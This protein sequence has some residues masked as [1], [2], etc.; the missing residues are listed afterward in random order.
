[1]IL[2]LVLILCTYCNQCRMYSSCL[3]PTCRYYPAVLEGLVQSVDYLLSM[4]SDA[5]FV[6]AFKSRFLS[7][8][9]LFFELMDKYGFLVEEVSS[10]QRNAVDPIIATWNFQSLERE[11]A[12]TNMLV[13]QC[14]N[15]NQAHPSSS[16]DSNVWGDDC[17]LII[18]RRKQH[19]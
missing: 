8:E 19:L 18:A 11:M 7:T 5:R 12:S 3:R 10:P 16:T 15:G 2:Y 6:L 4:K 1:M 9:Q 13:T 14:S 17:K